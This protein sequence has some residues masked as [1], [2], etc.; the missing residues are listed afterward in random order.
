MTNWG[1]DNDEYNT[2][3][4]GN[5]S[6][7]NGP[8]ALRDAY[9]AMKK[10]NEEL[11]AKLTSFLEDQQ[12]QKMAVVFESLGVPGAQSAYQ[13][14]ADPEKAK[15]WVNSMKSLFGGNQG[16]TPAVTDNQ[17]AAAPT[18]PAS[19]QAQFERFTEAGQNGTPAGSF[20][21]AQGAVG[22]ASSTQDIIA[23]FDRMNRM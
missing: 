15:E 8:K 2:D 6:E 4:Q 20:E 1:F 3:G 10:Q 13:G 19:M 17:P 9:S 5:D 7:L 16:G 18:L 22:D 23:A 21:A 11:N 14:P 12:R